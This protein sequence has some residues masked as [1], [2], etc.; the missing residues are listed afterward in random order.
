MSEKIVLALGGNALGKTPQEQLEKVKLT[1]K[2][3][4]DLVEEGNEVVVSHGNGPQVGMINLAMETSHNSKENTPDMPFPEC[5]AMSQGYIGYHLQNA[6]QSEFRK[7]NIDKSAVTVITQT[8]VDENDNAFEDPTKPIGSFY[9]KEQADKVMEEKGY[10]F[11]EDAGRGYRRVVASP[12][13]VDIVEI[14]AINKLIENDTM[15]IAAGGGGIP[16]IKKDGELIG[17]PAVIDKD[18]T[19]E[20]LAELL[21]CDTLLILTAVEK[22]AIRFGKEDQEWL[23]ELNLEQVDKYIEDGEFAKGSMLPK[24]EACKKFVESKDG[25]RAIITSLEKAKDALNGNTGTIIKK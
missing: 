9:T 18:F 1:A 17:V 4:V 22:V 5:G 16:V 8:V 24:V 14:N 13:P 7:R 12:K 23:S 19:S 21:D 2:S 11:K 20:K 3:I 10:V 25:K 6:I 15:V